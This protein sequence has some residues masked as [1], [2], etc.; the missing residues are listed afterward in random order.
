MEAY[1]HAITTLGVLVHGLGWWMIYRSRM[2]QVDPWGPMQDCAAG[3][4]LMVSGFVAALAGTYL[5]VR[6]KDRP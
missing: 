2:G 6:S 5:I 3:S 1:A 4:A